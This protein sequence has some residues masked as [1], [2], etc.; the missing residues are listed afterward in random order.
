MK[1]HF[2]LKKTKFEKENELSNGTSFFDE[3]EFD[4]LGMGFF[5][6]ELGFDNVKKNSMKWDIYSMK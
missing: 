4:K 3:M 5:V 6:D 1:V 2:F